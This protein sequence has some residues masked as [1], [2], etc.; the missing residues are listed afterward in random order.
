MPPRPLHHQLVLSRDIFITERM[1]MHLVW[2][3][4]RIFVKPIPR[5]LL[6]PD[7]WAENLSCPPCCIRSQTSSLAEYSSE[8]STDHASCVHERLWGSAL[9][10]LYSYAGLISHK[11]DFAIAQA[12]QLIPPEV[13]WSDWMTLVEEVLAANNLHRK[14]DN[15]FNYG[16]LRLSRLNKIYNV[17]YLTPLRGYMSHWQWT[18]YGDFFQE[19][20]AWLTAI[21]VYIAVVLGA[22]Q[23]GLGTD[24]L[25]GNHAF[26]SASY[27]FTV[28][29]I[30][31]P[32]V[33]LGIIG[34]LFCF[35]FIN[36]W[37]SAVA[38]KRKRFKA[39]HSVQRA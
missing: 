37:I 3:I 28:F 36:N 11:S 2:T 18:R 34:A 14:I 21:T 9:G 8:D 13:T 33:A 16:E 10:F 25:V 6:A 7:F 12:K 22:M 26:Q 19:N 23:V 29:S 39:I 5:F 1:D 35:M 20:L 27:G 38:F 17:R 32:L 15:R 24:A 4:G 31:G 30:L